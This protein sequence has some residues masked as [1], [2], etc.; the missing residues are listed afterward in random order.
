[1]GLLRRFA[2]L[3]FGDDIPPALRPLLAVTFSGSIAGSTTWS[4]M[5]IWAVKELDA[6]AQG[7]SVA[8]L[9]GAVFFMVSSYVG[10]HAS[11]HFGR[12]PV[13]LVGWAGGGLYLLGFI[14]ADASVPLGLGYLAC[15]ALIGGLGA[16]AGSAL[17]ADLV[18]PELHERAY[19]SVRIAANLGVTMGPPVGGLLLLLGW[20]ALFVGGA[21]FMSLAFVLAYRYLPSVGAYSPEGPPE[22]GSLGVIV[23]DRPFMF[24]MGSAILAWIVYVSYE[25]LLPVS[26]VDS[27]GVD[28]SV[29]GF[30][31]IIN[32]LLV[33]LFQM[34]VTRWASP[35][36]A[37]PKL[38]GALLL[39][40]LP[41]L[42]FSVSSALP[43]VMLVIVVFVVGEM[44]WVPTSQTVVAGLAPED[45]RGAYMGAFSG[46][47][48]V[49]FALAPFFG[50]QMRAV[51]GDDGMWALI[52]TISVVGAILGAVACRIA[53]GRLDAAEV[54]AT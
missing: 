54:P 30:L 27:H 39:M 2:R 24:F 38:F 11:D 42:L 25:V 8:F 28:E 44:L 4:F 17:V 29:W 33:T 13:M 49:G 26:L 50:F 15:Y 19:A 18:P 48:A 52:A 41:F 51:Y 37:A 12:R 23:R 35:I 47:A 9:I 32:P 1:V 6:G 21:L 53:F 7:L 20:N 3:I 40:G 36:P 43:L 14:L 22:R 46:A 5:G 10:G 31:V 45:V 16:S 34:R